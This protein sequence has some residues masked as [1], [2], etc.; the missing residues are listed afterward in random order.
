VIVASSGGSFWPSASVT[1]GSPRT[2]SGWSSGRRAW[3]K[4]G[5]P[6]RALLTH[7]GAGSAAGGATRSGVAPRSRRRSASI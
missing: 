2:E 1:P 4:G 7:R 3:P 6:T 5:R